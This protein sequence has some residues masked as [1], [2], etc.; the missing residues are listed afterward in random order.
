MSTLSLYSIMDYC[1]TVR[2]TVGIEAASF[3]IPVLTAGTGRYDRLG[4]TIDSDSKAQYLDRL[5]RIA[6]IPPLSADQRG[7][8]ERFAYG[9][10]VLRPLRLR[11]VTME[12]QRDAKASLRTKVSV[13]EGQT[14]RSATDLRSLA[15]WIQ[16]EEEDYLDAAP[17]RPA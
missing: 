4:F 12:Y 16:R 17:V 11:T 2:G 8:A 9:V 6:N 15:E 13:P 10:F 5:T 3:G 14:L 1:V 7:L